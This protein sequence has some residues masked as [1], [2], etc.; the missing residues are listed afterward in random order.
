MHINT[1]IQFIS[2][3]VFLFMHITIV[4]SAIQQGQTVKKRSH[5]TTTNEAKKFSVGE[6]LWTEWP[7]DQNCYEV[8]SNLI[9]I[10]LV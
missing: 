9:W 10:I 2:Y 1:L 7:T 6:I 3:P 8:K 5:D 4:K